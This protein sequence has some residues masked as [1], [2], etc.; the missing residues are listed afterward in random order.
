[1]RNYIVASVPMLDFLNVKSYLAFV[2][3]DN[4]YEK[5][6]RYQ[7]SFI[8]VIQHLDIMIKI[9]SSRDYPSQV[10]SP[11][12]TR[13]NCFTYFTLMSFLF[14]VGN[15]NGMA[16]FYRTSIFSLN[17]YVQLFSTSQ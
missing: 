5:K 15:L 13:S 8:I 2:I 16:N 17:L 10:C 9:I 12:H 11:Q 1:M 4:Q 14:K 6:K 3:R 7:N